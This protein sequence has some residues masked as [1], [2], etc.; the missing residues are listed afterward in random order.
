MAHMQKF[1]GSSAAH[2]I[3]H[4]EREKG[5]EGYLKYNNNS[6]INEERTPLNYAYQ[7]GGRMKLK[8]R[9][10]EVAP[11]RRK[12]A[13][14]MVDWIVTLPEQLLDANESVQ[15]KFFDI[16]ETF[17]E[18]RY[19]EKNVVCSYVHLDETTPH[20]HYCFVPVVIDKKSGNEKLCCKELMTKG[21]LNKFHKELD[22]QMAAEFNIPG[23]ILTGITK[24]SG[25]NQ[26]ISLLKAKTAAESVERLKNDLTAF[27]NKINAQINDFLSLNDFSFYSDLEKGM[28][29][30][31]ILKK[32]D[33]NRYFGKI[34][35]KRGGLFIPDDLLA[36]Y[37][38]I[39]PVM[40]AQDLLAEKLDS[41]ID[42]MDLYAEFDPIEKYQQIKQLHKE[43]ETEKSKAQKNKDKY[44][45]LYAEQL[46]LKDAYKSLQ[47][48][49][50]DLTN[51]NLELNNKIHEL[52]ESKKEQ[53]PTALIY[54]VESHNLYISQLD[55]RSRNNIERAVREFEA[56]QGYID[57]EA[58]DYVKEIMGEKLLV[59]EDTVNIVESEILLNT[60]IAF[61]EG[62]RWY[63][64]I[65]YED[66]FKLLLEF[67][68][69][70]VKHNPELQSKL[71]EL[72]MDD[73]Y[74]RFF[75][76]GINNLFE[77]EIKKLQP[78]KQKQKTIQKA[79]E[80]EW[81]LE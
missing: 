25:G 44:E 28:S 76:E 16:T 8:E 63:E 15:K 75:D 21:E 61:N 35:E 50:Y 68:Y 20:L 5:K 17:L 69:P 73:P 34:K 74:S 38:K 7:T 9:L 31:E 54:P 33:Y 24:E 40:A 39:L 57:E 42:A 47:V 51:E 4:C 48:R 37:F 60:A 64:Q 77:Y 22:K 71:Y 26:S 78:Q 29:A 14:T 80:K 66:K 52:R 67:Q 6:Y 19:G 70:Q 65:S 58:D 43:A 49:V 18:N 3:G 11:K 81:E 55:E 46:E 2:I 23:L 56:M 13:V 79:K 27:Q 62:K 10:N 1:K 72:Y 41:L 45:R 32:P 30:R 53:R 59:L 36:Q 12:D